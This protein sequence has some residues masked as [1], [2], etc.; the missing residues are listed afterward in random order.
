EVGV[1]RNGEGGGDECAGNTDAVAHLEAMVGRIERNSEIMMDDEALLRR[2]SWADGHVKN[3]KKGTEH[4]SRKARSHSVTFIHEG[5]TS[6]SAAS[7]L[8]LSRPPR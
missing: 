1:Q 5:R 3:R 8:G 6:A 4:N 7:W 2:C